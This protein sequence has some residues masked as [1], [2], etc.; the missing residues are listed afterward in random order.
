M[1][2]NHFFVLLCIIFSSSSIFCQFQLKPVIGINLLKGNGLSYYR[3][4]YSSSVGGILGVLIER[5][6]SRKFID[7][8]SGIYYKR[9]NFK[10]SYEDD[11]EWF[12]PI[13]FRNDKEVKINNLE[14]PI[15]VLLRLNRS[16][17]LRLLIGLYFGYAIKSAEHNN[18]TVLD[19]SEQN[20]SQ[21]MWLL[22][23]WGIHQNSNYTFKHK[24]FTMGMNLGLDY[25]FKQ[26]SLRFNVL[27]EG[28]NYDDYYY[29]SGF[30]GRGLLN[31]AYGVELSAYYRLNIGKRPKDSN[32]Q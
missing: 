7:F 28:A 2:R 16:K 9:K 27:Y 18:L 30:H 29:E 11:T 13:H 4:D 20:G 17:Q 22:Y 8:E 31:N 1:Y 23:Y 12:L 6:R 24:P 10:I 32:L 3:S 26:F 14:L 25:R 21:E 5:R 19:F 15:N